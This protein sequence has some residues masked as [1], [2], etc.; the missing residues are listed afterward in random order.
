SETEVGAIAALPGVKR[1]EVVRELHTM[2]DASV[3]LMNAPALW[4]RLGGVGNAGQGM[5]IAI[6]DT[7]IDISNPLFSD[8]GYTMPAGFPKT[9]H[10]SEALTNN[11]VIAAKSFLRSTS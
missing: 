1:I 5:K 3:P 4:D 6:L 9:N 7:G 8:T 2:L 11:K 10:G